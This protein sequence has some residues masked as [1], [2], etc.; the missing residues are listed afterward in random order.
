[1]YL[2]AEMAMVLLNSI[3]RDTKA[4]LKN[5]QEIIQSQSKLALDKRNTGAMSFALFWAGRLHYAL[6]DVKLAKEMWHRV[7]SEYYST[8]YGALGHYLLEKVDGKML[9]LSPS[10]ASTFDPE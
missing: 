6:G 5:S 8:F 4:A 1:K 9:V 7:A 10:R 3:N 2:D